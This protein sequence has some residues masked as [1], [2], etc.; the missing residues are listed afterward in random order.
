MISLGKYLHGKGSAYHE[1]LGRISEGLISDLELHGSAGAARELADNANRLREAVASQ[2][3]PVE[4]LNLVAIAIDS[5]KRHHDSVIREMRGPIAESRRTAHVLADDLR[6]VSNSQSEMQRKL[7]QM[8]NNLNTPFSPKES[9]AWRERM[10]QDVDAILSDSDTEA[11]AQR[12][13]VNLVE[14][15]SRPETTGATT[16][17][18]VDTTTG[19]PGRKHAESSI[20]YACQDGCDAVVVV[21]VMNNM[22]TITNSFGTDFGNVLLQRFAAAVR[23]RVG[24]YGEL[25][26][27][28][29]PVVIGLVRGNKAARVRA[30]VGE[31]LQDPIFVKTSNASVQVPI[32]ARWA[33]LPISASPRLVFQNVDRFADLP[34]ADQ[35]AQALDRENVTAWPRKGYIP[36]PPLFNRQPFRSPA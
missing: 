19:F 1:T 17:T 6:R 33:I 5:L 34:G 3:S 15:I 30:A 24:D 31:L 26:R 25:F 18:D 22:R 29:G 10:L 14:T 32:S 4:I 27:W 21:L 11:A 2:S 12:R 36:D 8:R 28:D 7:Q 23:D 16:T 35:Q 13:V 20:A 9:R